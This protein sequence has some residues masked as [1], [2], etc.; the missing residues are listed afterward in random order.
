MNN[1]E[2]QKKKASLKLH[3]ATMNLKPI[4]PL[5]YIVKD[6]RIYVLH[7]RCIAIFYSDHSS[8]AS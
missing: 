8:T 6:R 3:E 4:I 7:H 5:V 1:Q 2:K